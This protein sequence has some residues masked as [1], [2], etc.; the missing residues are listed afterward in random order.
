MPTIPVRFR[1]IGSLSAKFPQRYRVDLAQALDWLPELSPR[2]LRHLSASLGEA[3][4]IKLG[5]DV[6][7]FACDV[8]DLEPSNEDGA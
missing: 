8:M 6:A 2:E 1:C 3:I 7:P 4:A 5:V